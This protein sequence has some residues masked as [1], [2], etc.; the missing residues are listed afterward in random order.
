MWKIMIKSKI[1]VIAFLPCRQGSE[2][3]K[4]KN[5]RSFASIEGGLTYIKIQ[6]LLQCPEVDFIVVS[7]DDPY[8]SEICEKTSQQHTKELKVFER[9]PHLAAS[10]TSTDDLIRYVPEVI[11]EGIVLWTHVT[12]P[13]VD[14]AVYSDAIEK[15]TESVFLDECDSL[16][17]VTK[18]QKFLWNKNGAV[19]YDRDQ[20]K[21]PRTQTLHPLYEV[22]SAIFM[23]PIETYLNHHDRIGSR[24]YLFELTV[25]QAMDIDWE[26]DFKLA[27]HRWKLRN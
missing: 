27:E 23:A 8:V 9:P 21:W 26:E 12:S 11:S 15:Y 16:M 6:Q 17:S 20:E 13:F 22:N 1:P 2:R 19:N 4:E 25:S 14:S 7:T 3:V 24:V 18:I 10:G 5:T